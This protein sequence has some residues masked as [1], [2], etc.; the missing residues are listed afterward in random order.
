MLDPPE[1]IP[2]YP[3]QGEELMRLMKEYADLKAAQSIAIIQDFANWANNV[4]VHLLAFKNIL[5]TLGVSEQQWQQAIDESNRSLSEVQQ[6]SLPAL[7]E[8]LRKLSEI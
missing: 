1:M 8:L 5:K 6:S 2:P 4:T 7:A 3:T